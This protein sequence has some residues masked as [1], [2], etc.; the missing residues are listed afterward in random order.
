MQTDLDIS[1]TDRG[2]LDQISQLGFASDHDMVYT[3][4]QRLADDMNFQIVGSCTWAH[5]ILLRVGAA[6]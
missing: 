1:S 4:D 5:C 6:G 2:T 3:A